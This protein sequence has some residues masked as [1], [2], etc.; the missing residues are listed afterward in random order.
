MKTLSLHI[1][2]LPCPHRHAGVTLLCL[3]LALPAAARC[4]DED[5]PDSPMPGTPAAQASD[6]STPRLSLNAMVQEAIRRSNAVGAAK[7]L[8]EAAASDLEETRAASRFQATM[9]GTLGLAS[10]SAKDVKSQDGGQAVVSVNVTAPLWD[11]GRNAE[12]TGW[13]SSLA[14]AAR[15]GQ[16]TA[17][18]QVAFQ[19]VSLALERSRFR[20]QARVYQQYARK[21]ACL[22]EALEQI[23]RADKGRTSELVQAR[24][25]LQQAELSQTQTVAQLRQTET[26]L[27]RFIGDAMP[28]G[29]GMTALL[30]DV[31][32][33]AEMEAQAARAGEI[34]QLEAQAQALESYSRAVQAGHRPQVNW[35]LTGSKAAGGNQAG[36]VLAGISVSVPLLNPGAD[37]SLTAAQKR[38]EAARLQRAEALEARRNR[39]AEVIDQ[40]SSSFD[41]ARQVNAVLRNS[42]QVRSFTLQQWQQLGRRSLFDVMSA[43]GEHYNLRVAYVNALH[44]GQQASALLR[45]L[46]LGISA[47]LQ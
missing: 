25:T 43:E 31:P 36:T 33:L 4:I 18:E 27:R 24:K 45:S 42:D 23:V 30:L 41:R 21:T 34:N 11:A 46:G 14:D 44:D 12:L 9:S 13:R 38:A 10:A 29:E 5:T 1:S 32:P 3:A 22:V 7:L 16:L 20:Q 15:L 35:L 2:A 6:A 47:W 19:T 37:H 39:M 28:G 17:A 26:K 40:A 8:A